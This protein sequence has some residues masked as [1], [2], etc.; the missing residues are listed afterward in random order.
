MTNQVHK[1][2]TLELI[3]AVAHAIFTDKNLNPG[4]DTTKALVEEITNDIGLKM[5][6]SARNMIWECVKTLHQSEIIEGRAA[7]RFKRD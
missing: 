5:T 3:K 6:P 1:T 7:K 2:W 4:K